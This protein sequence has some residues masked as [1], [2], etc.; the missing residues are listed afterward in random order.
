MIEGRLAYAEDLT[1]LSRQIVG[2]VLVSWQ[3]V[4]RTG[5]ITAILALLLTETSACLLT[6]SFPPAP[7]THLVAVALAVALG[8]GVAVTALFV[9][10]LRGGVSFIR[11]LEG[12]AEAGTRAAR[13]F[14]RREVGDL[15]AGLRRFAHSQDSKDHDKQQRRVIRRTP[16]AI[17]RPVVAAGAEVAVSEVAVVGVDFARATIPRVSAMPP[18][19]GY[20]PDT[21]RDPDDAIIRTPAPAIQSLPVLAARLP[22]IEWTYDD[23]R[24][25]YWMSPVAHGGVDAPASLEEAVP[26]MAASTTSTEPNAPAIDEMRQSIAIAHD[27]EAVDAK[28]G[29]E[30]ALAATDFLAGGPQ[31][32]AD[33]PG[34]IPR[35]WR[36]GGSITRPLPAVTRPN[37]GVRSGGLW[38]RVSQALVG[39]ATAPQSD[40]EFGDEGE[41][42]TQN[43]RLP[44]SDVTSEDAWL[45]G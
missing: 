23:Q 44:Q 24:P 33:V 38:E 30:H 1:H 43:H 7:A 32:A 6:G 35:G 12:E 40:P 16:I 15:G 11:H 36:R 28:A 13:V 8:Y 19:P 25:L 10:L 45:N 39:D 41:P 31:G 4:L 2:V 29:K 18:P 26:V 22:R 20:R 34:L 21:R 14:A 27:G 37:G 17:S 5:L 3:R 9:M 42:D